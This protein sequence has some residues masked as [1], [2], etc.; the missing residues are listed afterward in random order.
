MVIF[1]SCI[2][3]TAVLMSSRPVYCHCGWSELSTITTQLSYNLFNSFPRIVAG[4]LLPTCIGGLVHHTVRTSLTIISRVFKHNVRR[5]SIWHA[6]IFPY[7]GRI[8]RLYPCLPPS[9]LF[10]LIVPTNVSTWP[11]SFLRTNQS[12]L[13]AYYVITIPHGE[14]FLPITLCR[15][16]TQVPSLRQCKGLTWYKQRPS[17]LAILNRLE[18]LVHLM[19]VEFASLSLIGISCYIYKV[20]TEYYS[21]C[22]RGFLVLHSWTPWLPPGMWTR[23]WSR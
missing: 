5:E 14:W 11:C 1:V 2:L 22:Q 13:L 15:A 23:F 17:P 19:Y 6:T 4:K 8:V 21:S 16:T 7:G 12:C 20:V 18:Y 9:L 3:Y 10:Q